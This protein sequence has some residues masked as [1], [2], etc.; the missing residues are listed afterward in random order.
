MSSAG[1][2]RAYIIHLLCLVIMILSK[3]HSEAGMIFWG[4]FSMVW[5]VTTLV[6]AWREAHEP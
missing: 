1:T 6:R 5:L 2:E 3:E 4:A